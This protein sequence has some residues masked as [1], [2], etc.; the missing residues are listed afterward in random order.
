MKYRS[1]WDPKRVIEEETRT[2]AL[3]APCLPRKAPTFRRHGYLPNITTRDVQH[4]PRTQYCIRSGN[5]ISAALDVM[6]I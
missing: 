6:L 5:Y 2:I 4:S 1:T 3:D